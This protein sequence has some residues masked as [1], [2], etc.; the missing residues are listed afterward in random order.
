M[1]VKLF[2]TANCEFCQQEAEWLRKHEIEF[3]EVFIDKDPA[4]AEEMLHKTGQMGVPVT[5]IVEDDSSVH[6]VIGF[7]QEKLA[8]FLKI[9][10]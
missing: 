10:T 5:E 1:N 9:P 8:L 7:D 2:N 3:K 4:Q 6:Y